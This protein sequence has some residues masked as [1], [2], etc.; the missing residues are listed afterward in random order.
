VARTVPSFRP[1]LTPA[2]AAAA[3]AALA[4][5]SGVYQALRAPPAIALALAMSASAGTAAS[6]REAGAAG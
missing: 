4:V 3:V 2:R 6:G 5:A 1:T